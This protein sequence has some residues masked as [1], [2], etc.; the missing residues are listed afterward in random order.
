MTEITLSVKGYRCERCQ[1]T[2]I[3]KNSKVPKTCPK[4]RS[5]YW[6]HKRERIGNY[7]KPKQH[8]R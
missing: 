8:K 1:Y 5:S 4:C 2:W 6:E 3:P 7:Q